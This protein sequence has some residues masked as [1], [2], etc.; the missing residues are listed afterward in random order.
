MGLPVESTGEAKPM[1]DR[2][3]PAALILTLEAIVM[4][5]ARAHVATFDEPGKQAFAKDIAANL[6]IIC[7]ELVAM[8]PVIGRGTTLAPAARKAA[9]ARIRSE[10]LELVKDFVADLIK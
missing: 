8:A 10:A 4:A 7:A 6:D 9:A 1:K 3:N 2:S 5:V